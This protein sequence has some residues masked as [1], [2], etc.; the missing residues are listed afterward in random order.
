VP[1]LQ[2]LHQVNE[3]RASLGLARL[4]LSIKLNEAAESFAYKYIEHASP[5]Y[6]A[7]QQPNATTAMAYI[8]SA[9]YA[10]SERQAAYS[11]Q[12][13]NIAIA[14]GPASATP[15]NYWLVPDTTQPDRIAAASGI[16]G[17]W[18]CS[19]ARRRRPPCCAAG[20][21]PRLATLRRGRGRG[22][23][24]PAP[25]PGWVQIGRLRTA[26]GPPPAS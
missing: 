10:F 20:L 13:F 22:A 16:S 21:P 12:L 18:G 15:G 23:P 14:E 3:A 19:A 7:I 2:V 4:C 24:P 26:L 1:A 17:R 6:A 9:G 11:T 8:A 25:G 5:V